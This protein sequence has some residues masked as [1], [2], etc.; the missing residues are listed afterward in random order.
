[1]PETS[2][3]ARARPLADHHLA[4]EASRNYYVL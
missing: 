2:L 3:V 4:K 1:M